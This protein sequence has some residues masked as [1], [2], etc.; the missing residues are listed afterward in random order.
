MLAELKFVQGAVSRKDFIPAMTHFAIENGTVRSYNGVLALCSPI[1]LDINCKPKAATLVQAI[2]KCN[3]TVSLSLTPTGRLSIKSGKFKAFIECIEGETP[4]VNPEGERIDFDGEQFITALKAV[5]PFIGDDASRPWS[6]G[7]LFKDCSAFATNNVI[8][9]EYWMGIPFPISINVPEQAIKE[10]LRIKETPIYGQV[11]TNSLSLH[12]SDGRWIRTQL[13]ETG[14][15]DI[16]KILDK[17]SNFH[18]LP[19][20]FFEALESVKPLLDKQNRIYFKPGALT[21]SEIE[22]EGASFELDGFNFSGVYNFEM[23]LLLEGTVSVIDFSL[24]PSP[25]LFQGDRIRGAIIGLKQ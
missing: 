9:V 23:L 16:C 14:W 8:A 12:Y 15:P 19:E 18:K 20:N 1:P 25:C 6:N 4:H 3:E 2:A 5:S 13:M 24:Y 10:I 22:G 7:V 17:P 11:T 21:T